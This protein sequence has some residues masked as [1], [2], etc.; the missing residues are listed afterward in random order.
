MA[1]ALAPVLLGAL[2]LG[3]ALSLGK[4]RSKPKAAPLVFDDLVLKSMAN[5]QYQKDLKVGDIIAVY[6]GNKDFP[7]AEYERF[8]LLYPPWVSKGAAPSFYQIYDDIFEEGIDFEGKKTP[9][10]V[11]YETVKLGTNLPGPKQWNYYF[12]K[13]DEKYFNTCSDCAPTDAAVQVYGA[14]RKLKW[15]LPG[16]KDRIRLPSFVASY[17]GQVIELFDSLQDWQRDRIRQAI[18]ATRYNG[19]VDA[20]RS[21]NDIELFNQ[22]DAVNYWFT[23]L[24]LGTQARLTADIATTLGPQK[25]AQFKEILL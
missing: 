22:I 6:V 7:E 4:K 13:T 5:E 16:A 15:T 25:M 18:G 23:S 21:R 12:I 1:L 24:P 14:N 2:G 3:V 11:G 20:A 9:V 8:S 17:S 19:L 10:L